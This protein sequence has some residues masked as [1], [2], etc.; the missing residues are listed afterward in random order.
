VL[1]TDP[2]ATFNCLE[3]ALDN[4]A[5]AATNDAAVLQQLTAANLV[6]TNTAAALTATNKKLVDAVATRV[7][8]TAPATDGHWPG[9]TTTNKPFKGNYCW[10]HGHKVSKAHTS[11]T[12]LF[13]AAGHWKDATLANTYGGSEKDKGWDT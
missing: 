5:L 4:L 10:T 7:P 1:L 13:P 3:V 6:L 2:P 9:S 8:A 12:C 11:A